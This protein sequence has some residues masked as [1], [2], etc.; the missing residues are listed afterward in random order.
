MRAFDPQDELLKRWAKDASEYTKYRASEAK[1]K[2]NP[3]SVLKRLESYEHSTY[4]IDVDTERLR[5]LLLQEL[6]GARQAREALRE[7]EFPHTSYNIG[8]P[9]CHFCGGA[10]PAW[11]PPPGLKLCRVGHF[12]DCKLGRLLG[13]WK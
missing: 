13:G 1:D 12:P 7:V 11:E 8:E 6:H 3:L 4:E 2:S 9:V 5:S 10:D